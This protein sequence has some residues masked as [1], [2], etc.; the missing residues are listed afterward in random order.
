MLWTSCIKLSTHRY[1]CLNY[2]FIAKF[3]VLFNNFNRSENGTIITFITALHFIAIQV[4][5]D[6]VDS[7]VKL[8]KT[9]AILGEKSKSFENLWN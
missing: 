7:P 9:T 4:D 8:D 3:N 2:Y 6:G 5:G 1:S